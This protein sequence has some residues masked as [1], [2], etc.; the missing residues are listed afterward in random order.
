MPPEI[1]SYYPPRA[2]LA[3]RGLAL[4][5]KWLRQAWRPRKPRTP[6]AGEEPPWRWLFVPGQLWRRQGKPRL[7][8]WIT[9]VW[10]GALTFSSVA[11]NPALAN[12]AALLASGL[13]GISAAA[14]L[15]GRFPHWPAFHRLWRTPLLVALGILIFYG[16]IV[17]PAVDLFAQ[18]ITARGRTVMIQPAAGLFDPEWRR[19]DWV[20][21]QIQAGPLNFDRILAG[22]GDTIRFYP[23]FF[24]VG[25]QR[26]ERVS[27]DMPEAGKE[28][29]LSKEY[30]IWPTETKLAH[31]A[32]F[33]QALLTIARVPESSLLGKPW[34][35]WFWRKQLPPALEIW[36]DPHH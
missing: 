7:G 29:L 4:G 26:F 34:S 32:D 18:R 31:G 25:G 19:G 16:L 35:R 6:A 2:G 24:E 8:T 33:T 22:P 14:F 36:Q 28:T 3:S 27:P 10:A 1:S 21:Y 30:F 9:T 13:H 5:G 12:A 15:N 17:R 11:L 23:A 20:A